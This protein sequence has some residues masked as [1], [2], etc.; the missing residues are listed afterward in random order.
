[1][2]NNKEAQFY[3]CIW[4]MKTW[5]CGQVSLEELGSKPGELLNPAGPEALWWPVKAGGP[6]EQPVPGVL[7]HWEAEGG[8]CFR[9]GHVPSSLLS[10]PLDLLGKGSDLE[11]SGGSPLGFIKMW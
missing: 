2:K 8:D 5:L 11:P 3:D 1:M 7:S 9:G 10:C 4:L 6:Q